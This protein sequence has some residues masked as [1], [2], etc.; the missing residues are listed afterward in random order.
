MRPWSRDFTLQEISLLILLGIILVSLAYFEFV[1]RPV[2]RGMADAIEEGKAAELAWETA[3]TQLER[4]E[5]MAVVAENGSYMA[6]YD[7]HEAELA[8]VDDIL[9]GTTRPTVSITEVTRD[10]DLIRQ[11][12]AIQFTTSDYD[13]VKTV[14]HGLC[15][16]EYRCLVKDV[17]CSL[18]KD[19]AINV[20]MTATFYETLA[21]EAG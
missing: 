12:I 11:D 7:N 14:V 17:R 4:L 13:T 21:D 6:S 16:S 9:S 10:G 5:E 2:R 15:N 3:Q 8:L 1:D 20:S 19:E 18:S